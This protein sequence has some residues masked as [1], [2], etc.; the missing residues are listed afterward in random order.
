MSIYENQQQSIG[1]ALV[2]NM[3]HLTGERTTGQGLKNAE[4]N[5]QFLSHGRS[6]AELRNQHLAEGEHCIVIAAGPSIKRQDPLSMLKKIDYKGAIIAT[7]SALFYCLRN[8]II[9]DLVVTLDPHA[10]RIVRWFGDPHLTKEDIIADDYF[11]R[12]DMDEVFANELQVNDEILTLLDKYGKD[13]NIALS[14]SASSAVVNRAIDSKMKIYWWNPMYDDPEQDNSVTQGLYKRNQLPCVNAGG[15]V[16]TACWMMAH[17]VLNKKCVA[18][19]GMD[20]GY[21]EDTPYEK[22]QYYNEAV[23]L[24]GRDQL[25]DYFIR[26][27]NPYENQWYY[28]DP[29]Y[30]WYRECLFDL[31]PEAD[32]VTYNSTEGGIVFGDNI[33]YLPLHEFLTRGTT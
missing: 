9:P 24:F 19:T 3:L 11:S 26:V 1:M 12:Q 18:M 5:Q 30:M 13:I 15:N 21:Y 33:E 25:D 7:D 28:T 32:C 4:R 14:T 23:T 17:A 8:H 29:A 16:G 22:T 6:L 10:K 2:E 20:F 31:L 27:F